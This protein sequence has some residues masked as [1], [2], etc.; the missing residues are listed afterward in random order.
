MRWWSMR[1]PHLHSSHFHSHGFIDGPAATTRVKLLYNRS[2][3]DDGLNPPPAVPADS[4]CSGRLARVL[5]IVGG[6]P[7]AAVML[8]LIFLYSSIGSAWP[9]IR[10]GAL[11]DWL[12]IELLRFEK[13]EMQWFAWWP[14]HLLIAM[15]CLGLVVATIRH[16]PRRWD[17]LGVLLAHV[18]VLVIVVSSAAYFHTK[19]EGDTV[20]FAARALILAPGMESPAALVVRPE[21]R[22][23]IGRAP[24]TYDIA[25]SRI[26]PN[27]RVPSGPYQGQVSSSIWLTIQSVQPPRQFTRVLYLGYQNAVYDIASS[28]PAAAAAS[29]MGP[30]IDTGLQIQLD[31]DPAVHM[32]HTHLPP[33]HS[34]GAIYARLDPA[35]EWS[36]LRLH[37]LPHYYE[38]VTTPAEV[39]TADADD[40]LPPLRAP[41]VGI[42]KF[43]DADKLEDLQF[44]V[45]DYLPY[46][47]WQSRWVA[48]GS[49]LNPL[50]RFSLVAGD[51]RERHEMAAFAPLFNQV[52]LADNLDAQF[53]WAATAAERERL[54]NPA[55]ARILIRRK[56]GEPEYEL[57]LSALSD[58]QRAAIPESDYILSLH[59]LLPAGAAM[60]GESPALAVLAI[61]RGDEKFYRIAIANQAQDGPDL[62]EHLQPLPESTHK[63][64]ELHYIPAASP[65]LIFLGR[66]DRDKLDMVLNLADGSQQRFE[67]GQGES[68]EIFPGLQVAIHAFAP[69]ARQEAGPAIVAR[70]HRRPLQQV[71]K[72]MSMIRVTVAEGEDTH[73][74]WLPFSDYAFPDEQRAQPGRFSYRPVKLALADGRSLE[75]LYSRWREPLPA[76]VALDRFILETHPGGDRPSDYI[77]LITFRQQEEWSPITAVRSNEPAQ[78]GELWYFQSQWDPG[79][80]C[81]TVLGVANRFGV[82]GML[83][84]ALISIFGILWAF[85]VQPSMGPKA[86]TEKGEA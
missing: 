30:L 46:A 39:S 76:E 42:E 56:P 60:D 10:Q 72:S 27:D 52:K 7:F 79:T 67:A 45:T 86:E 51:A 21:A 18:G 53:V 22:I 65:K 69:Y 6:I 36:Q 28:T 2:M 41:Q 81:H 80:Q 20:V 64:L 74:V 24:A 77:S 78:H 3:P 25:V 75:L 61:E 70:A 26:V 83:A 12:Q 35:Q 49:Q 38:Y 85:Y 66:P 47:E 29:Q 59:H 44:Q 73:S 33:M 50:L 32:Y 11:A 58:E 9:P 5:N 14:F 23:T 1:F 37:G 4:P 62:D 55:P 8:A 43:A 48:G 16:V 19:K 68:V 17:K 34:V 57:P 63:D 13:S 82:H 84:G 54:L 40:N 15:F 31:Y 71:G